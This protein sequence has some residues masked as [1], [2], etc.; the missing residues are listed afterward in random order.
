M[1]I[2][3]SLDYSDSDI[4][5]S[6]SE[7]IPNTIIYKYETVEIQNG[8][9]ILQIL[10]DKAEVYD[11]KEKTYLTNVDFYNYKDGDVN[12]YGSSDFAILNMK[13]GDAELTGLI[14]IESVEDETSLKA[15]SLYWN[16]EDKMLTSNREDS[17]TVKDEDGSILSGSGFSADIKRK[18]I[19]FEGKTEGEYITDEN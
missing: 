6:L 14:E 13:S 5:E 19:L 15:K 9:P 8:S 10:A 7:E 1:T 17:V 3:C 16:D 4:V 18:T 11:S 2:G 12:N